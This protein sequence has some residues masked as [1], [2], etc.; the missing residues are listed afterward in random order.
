MIT[1]SKL[2]PVSRFVAAFG[3]LPSSYKEAMTY[4]EQLVWLCNY[5]ET[6]ILPAINNNADGLAELQNLYVELKDYVD[7]YF[8]NLDIQAEVNAK[9]EAM[10]ESGQLEE[11]I[12]A[13]LQV[14]GVLGFDTVADMKAGTNFIDGSIA[15]TLGNLTYNDGKGA[16][17]YIRDLKNTDVIDEVHI[18]AITEYPDLVAELIPD[19]NIE[20]INSDISQLSQDIEDLSN[21]TTLFI[22]DS[23]GAGQSHGTTITPWCDYTAACLGLASTDW[24]NFSESGAGF[25]TRGHNNH[26]LLE[27]L[28][29]SISQ[30]TDKTKIKRVVICEGGNDA[31]YLRSNNISTTTV[32]DTAIETFIN[33]CKTQFPNAT[34][35]LG[36]VSN[37]NV[38]STNTND[39]AA[40][41]LFPLVIK[42]FKNAIAENVKY[43]TGVEFI[44]KDYSYYTD[45]DTSHPIQIGYQK[46]GEGIAQ[47]ILT[48][49]VYTLS[50]VDYEDL[51]LNSNINSSTSTI[52]V[53][54]TLN[55]DNIEFAFADVDIRFS[56]NTTWGSDTSDR[57]ILTIATLNS[58]H[59]KP[60]YN[61]QAKITTTG[62]YR[63]ADN[64]TYAGTFEISLD[65]AGNLVINTPILD[66]S[67]FH[68]PTNVTRLVFNGNSK[69]IPSL[70]C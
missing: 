2:S 54:T 10:V 15:R 63:Q 53:N 42:A 48:G 32:L 70:M 3:M 13:Y 36:M 38:N 12:A 64:K 11:I 67:N 45:G 44:L 5:L 35:Y 8:D 1:P 28:Q 17:Y 16:F 37:L 25:L 22:G 60:L 46:L 18:L 57:K 41:K 65:T 43:L 40:K 62:W 52:L 29:A 49:S 4:E 56:T 31:R 33:Y 69:V 14:K 58:K 9:I 26:T 21:E 51:T 20:Q 27:L 47:A 55:N 7:N 39:F 23:Y 61:N 6:E 19:Y 30:I 24:Y 34:Y 50:P 66:N 59:I 68:T